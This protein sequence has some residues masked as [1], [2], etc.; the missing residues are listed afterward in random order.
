LGTAGTGTIS[1]NQIGGAS[2]PVSAPV[3]GT[4]GSGQLVNAAP[5]PSSAGGT[6]TNNA[7]AAIWAGILNFGGAFSTVQAGA[8]T[9]T[10]TGITNVSFPTGTYT[11]GYLGT[12]VNSQ[13]GAYSIVASDM[14]KVVL[15]TDASAN[16]FNIQAN[17]SVSIPVSLCFAIANAP[18]G[19][20]LSITITS[21]TLYWLPTLA[22]GTRTMAAGG[23]ATL[24]KWYGT[25]SWA[26]V[27]SAGVT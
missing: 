22:T 15:N 19:G 14:G 2:V 5:V 1:A 18:G 6:S 13:T 25:T 12:P 20:T 21:D 26:M 17:A 3:V 7:F 16:T 27:S 4:N 23:V 8:V 9:Q 10:Y 11:A 24:C